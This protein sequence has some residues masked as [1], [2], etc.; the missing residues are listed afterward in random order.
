MT[1]VAVF[2]DASEILVVGLDE[3]YNPID[4]DGTLFGPN[5]GRN[6]EDFDRHGADFSREIIK[7]E[8]PAYFKVSVQ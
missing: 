8:L 6:I 2:T 5:S 1:K 4:L 3:K 7:I